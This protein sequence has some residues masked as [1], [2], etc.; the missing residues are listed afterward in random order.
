MSFE[1]DLAKTIQKA[2][3]ENQRRRAAILAFEERWKEV[4]SMIWNV[5]KQA[6]AVLRQYQVH[7]SAE[8]VDD[9]VQLVVGWSHETQ[10]FVHSLRFS[11]G[12]ESG[13]IVCVSS[14]DAQP[15]ALP[16]LTEGMVESRVQKFLDAALRTR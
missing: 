12:A 13:Q 6:E 15:E 16:R 5:L 3:A 7:A 4:R 11:P 1:E 2:S 10:A 9:A 8:L 14:V